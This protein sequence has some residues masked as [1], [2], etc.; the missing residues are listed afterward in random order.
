MEERALV[1]RLMRDFGYPE[2]GAYLVARKVQSMERSIAAAFEAWWNG[3][4]PERVEVEGY[5]VER[6]MREHGLKPIGAFLTLDWL[7]REP[8]KA[9][10]AVAR[11]YDYIVT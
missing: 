2:Q 9:K 3:T 1:E 11:G 7:A 6:L 4:V 5:T 8:E 10:A